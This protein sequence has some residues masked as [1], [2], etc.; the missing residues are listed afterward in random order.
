M[1]NIEAID[2]EI[3]QI[4]S[5]SMRGDFVRRP[6]QRGLGQQEQRMIRALTIQKMTPAEKAAFKERERLAAMES[7]RAK[8]VIGAFKHGGANI[9]LLP[10]GAVA[11]GSKRG[12]MPKRVGGKFVPLK[13]DIER[14]PN[15]YKEHY[16]LFQKLSLDDDN[17]DQWLNFFR[18]LPSREI[19]G[20]PIGKFRFRYDEQG[21]RVFVPWTKKSWQNF[22]HHAQRGRWIANSPFMH[23]CDIN[24]E[25]HWVDKYTAE[26]RKQATYGKYQARGDKRKVWQHTAG[27]SVCKKKKKSLWMKIRGPVVAAVAIVA[28]VYLGPIVLAKVKAVAGGIGG[29]GAAGGGAGTGAAGAAAGTGVS[30]TVTAATTSQKILSGAKT[31]VGYVNKARTVKAIVKGEMPPVP[32]GIGGATFGQWAMI[33]AKEEIKK[34][35]IDKAMDE[36]VKYIEKKMTKKEEDKIRAEIAAL[37]R[38][39]DK[40]TPPEVKKLPPEP[41]PE[42]AAPIKKMQ[43]IEIEKKNQLDQFIIPGAIVAGALILGG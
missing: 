13:K 10:S 17:P 34:A 25:N 16:A 37:Q 11:T 18:A 29:A 26:S 14:V 6:G 38:E 30:G 5:G 27:A 43:Q 32:I 31:L 42:L 8:S 19:R 7:A 22:F 23:K 41:M 36:G 24:W 21:R 1:R 35:A 15:H 40:A 2:R 9:Y 12:P 39:I 3:A 4:K 33:V 28:A 20:L